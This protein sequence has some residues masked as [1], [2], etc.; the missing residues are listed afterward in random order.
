[1]GFGGL[2]TSVTGLMASRNSLDTISHNISNSNNNNY[3]RQSA[4]HANNRYNTIGLGNM[5]VGTGVNVQ[6]VRQIRDEFLDIKL[7]RELDTFGYHNAKSQVL[8]DIEGV[9]N[10]ITNSGLQN[11]MDS[12]LQNVMDDFWD[13]WNELVK[14]PSELTI[15]GLVH[16]S[17]V[18]FTDT[19]NHISNQLNDIKQNLNK[20]IT[21]KVDEANDILDKI[22]KLNKIIRVVEGEEVSVKANDFRDERNALLDRLSVLLPVKSYEN[23]YGEATVSLFGQDLISGSYTSRLHIENDSKGIGYIYF[24]SSNEKIDLRGKGEIGGYI[25]VRDKSIDEYTTRLDILVGTMAEEVN[26]L[27]K[28]GIDLEG[29]KGIEFFT[30]INTDP[31][32]LLE[33]KDKYKNAAANIKVNSDLANFNKIAV[34]ATG[35]KGDGDIAKGIYEIRKKH[36]FN[37]YGRENGK[38]MDSDDYYR[39]LILSLGLE[40][41]NSRGIAES[42]QFLIR[43]IDERRKSISAVSLDEEMADMIKFQHSYV[44]NSRVIN[45]IDEMIDTIVNRM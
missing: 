2:Y 9:F 22:G 39:D 41:K 11:V 7:R 21:A 32:S 3:V 34:S 35:A 1:M 45:A 37:S 33:P 42:Q 16:E 23:K 8:G 43:N 13:N 17:S 26:V 30:G 38:L 40:R 27:H 28:T 12:G 15:R 19:V 20:E 4:I 10:E 5:Q 18:A 25:D 44:A 31:D 6:E 24:Q 14:D 29:K 36:I